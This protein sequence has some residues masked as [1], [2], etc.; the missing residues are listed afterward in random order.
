M[1]QSSTVT[2]PT[3]NNKLQRLGPLLRAKINIEVRQTIAANVYIG[4]GKS[5][6]RRA[7]CRLTAGR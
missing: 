7:G 6:L 1:I 2:P 5:G 4:G 3:L